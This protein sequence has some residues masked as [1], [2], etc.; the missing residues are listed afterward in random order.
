MASTSFE[1][2][3]LKQYI[4]QY[5][6]EHLF[7]NLLRKKARAAVTQHNLLGFAARALPVL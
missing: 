1:S 7:H 6:I 3:P 2:V 5:I 4:I